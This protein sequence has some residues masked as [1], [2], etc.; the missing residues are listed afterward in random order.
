MTWFFFLLYYLLYYIVYCLCRP[1]Y[2]LSVITKA[3]RCLYLV[4]RYCLFLLQKIRTVMALIKIHGFFVLI[5]NV[6]AR[7]TVH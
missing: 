4:S 6:I 5:I 3:L 2:I 7:Y 1:L